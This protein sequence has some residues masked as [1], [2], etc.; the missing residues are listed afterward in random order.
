MESSRT[1]NSIA[2]HIKLN[3]PCLQFMHVTT[4]IMSDL[5]GRGALRR[6]PEAFNV[7]V[8][9]KP[10]DAVSAEFLRIYDIIEFRAPS[11]IRELEKELRCWD[12]RQAGR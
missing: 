1:L 6:L 7:A 10:F 5:F 12:V 3:G 2:E 11:T 8:Y 9:M 4:R